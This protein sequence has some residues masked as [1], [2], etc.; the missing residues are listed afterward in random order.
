[1]DRLQ[2]FSTEVTRVAR[3]VGSEGRLGGQAKIEDVNGVWSELTTNVN[4][5]ASNLT[6]QVRSIAQGQKIVSNTVD[7][8]IPVVTTAVARGDLT[9]KIEVEASGEILE[10]KITINKMYVVKPGTVAVY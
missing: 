4:E 3:E 6:S 7:L 8:L 1:M 2:D 9:R 10:L 5:M